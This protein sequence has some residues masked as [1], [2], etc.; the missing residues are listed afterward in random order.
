LGVVYGYVYVSVTEILRIDLKIRPVL[1][2]G[3]MTDRPA[4]QE[5]VSE[6]L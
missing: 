2:V 6:H 3:K 5:S 4:R 1:P